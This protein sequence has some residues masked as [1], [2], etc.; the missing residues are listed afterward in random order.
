MTQHSLFPE[1]SSTTLL[2]GDCRKIFP[3]LSENSIDF[4]VTSPP[5]AQARRQQYGGISHDD[6]VNWFL[7]ISAELLRVLKPSGS[8]ELNIKENI[9]DGE[10]SCYVADLIKSLRNQSGRWTDEYCWSKKNAM[11]GKWKNRFRDAW[12]R[13]LHFNKT[14]NFTMYQNAVMVHRKDSTANRAN[15]V[16]PEYAAR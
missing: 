16:D 9:V 2:E 15:R 1:E 6:Y 3:S 5:Y 11:P 12:E 8:F 14:K 10:R 7:P 4:I 13:L